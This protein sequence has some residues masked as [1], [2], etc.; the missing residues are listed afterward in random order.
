M[1]PTR[2]TV[3]LT[4]GLVTLLGVPAAVAA[5]APSTLYVDNDRAVTDCS[6]AGPG[7]LDLPYCT[8]SA[9]AGAARPGQTVRIHTAKP[10]P[11]AVTIGRSG[12]PGKPIA[13]VADG[14]AAGDLVQ[15]GQGQASGSTAPPTWCCAGCAPPEGSR[16]AVPPTSSWTGS[17]APRPAPP[18]SSWTRAAP[19]CA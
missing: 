3:L 4:A 16:S 12:E 2:A 11:E 5:D 13:F 9:A 15:I 1:R 14:P 18:P 8:I 7:S 6:D 17:P 10:Y 19:T